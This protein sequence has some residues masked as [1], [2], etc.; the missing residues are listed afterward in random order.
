MVQME[1]LQ[2]DMVYCSVTHT[3]RDPVSTD[4]NVLLGDPG[5]LSSNGEEPGKI[6]D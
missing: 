5:D 2:P 4:D 6:S 1:L 3:G